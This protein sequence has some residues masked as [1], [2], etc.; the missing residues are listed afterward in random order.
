MHSFLISFKRIYFSIFLILILGG[1]FMNHLS[2]AKEA[3][4]HLLIDTSF[5]LKVKKLKLKNGLTV[6]FYP[7]TR[8]DVVTINLCI[9]VGSAFEKDKE[10]G[11]THLIEHMIFKGT[12][13]MGPEEIAKSI[14][15]LGGYINAFTSYDYTCYYVSGPSK[16][17]DTALKILSESVFNPYFP[18]KELEK[19]KQVVLEEMRMRLDRPLSVL[20]EEA[21][22]NSYTKYPYKRPIIGYEKTVESFTREDLLNYVHRFYSPQNAYLIVVGNLNEKEALQKIEKFFSSIP[23][24]EIKKVHFPEEP[25]N[26][27]PKFFWIKRDVKENYFMLTFPGVSFRSEDLPFVDLLVQILGGSK[28]SRFYRII[29]REKNLVNAIECS[30]FTPYGPGLIEITGTTSLEKFEKAL[31]A[32]LEE[33][34]KIKTLPPQEEELKRAKM[35]LLSD[36][37]Y[38]QETS[39][40]LARTIGSFELLRGNYRDVEWYIKKIEEATPEDI[41]NTAKKYLDL[42]KVV[43]TLLSSKKPFEE[44]YFSELVKNETASHVEIYTLKNKLK[45]ILLPRKDI[46]TFAIS[47]VFPG[48]TRLETKDTNGLFKALS[49]LWTRG[50]THY[51]ADEIFEKLSLLG[52]TINGFSGRNTFGLKGVFLSSYLDEGLEIFA[53][54]VKHPVFSQE[55]CNKARNTLISSILTQEDNPFSLALKDFLAYIFPSHPYGLN[56]E[57]SKKFFEHFT[58]EDM[59]K[60]YEKFA[61]PSKGVL[62]I[63]GDFPVDYVKEKIKNLFENWK[64]DVK[65]S[66]KEEKTPP[67]PK[68]K[69]KFV[70]KESFQTQIFLGFQT[71][72]LNSSE[73]EA[74]ELLSSALSGQSGRLFKIL[75]EKEALAYTV[76]PI[77]IFYPKKSVFL[78]YIGCAPKKTEKAIKGFWKIIDDLS[79]NGLTEEELKRGKNMIVGELKM[80]EQSNIYKAETMAVDEVL[81][82]GWNYPEKFV[83]KVE[84]LTNEN[85]KEVV[86]KYLTPENS[87]LFILG[88][89]E[90]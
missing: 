26:N 8:A 14:E 24:R 2:Q 41:L 86:K 33:I 15:D 78:F 25:F 48:G 69:E 57:G 4:S 12:K 88:P 34:Q 43:L 13:D 90:K 72:G 28:A 75:R 40:G 58:H 64:K 60:A 71:P 5:L 80:S 82:L 61:I 51:T 16:V 39:E 42:N 29:K 56:P 17:F 81:G 19:E 47:L 27:K 9:H 22:K 45:V 62:T 85:I 52:G 11:I 46:P 23:E 50:T 3:D 1:F 66:Y 36:F 54:I 76:V 30:D 89:E 18:E 38:S 68:E 87:F 53:E 67:K 63:V 37:I 31:K 59:I 35:E 49:Y 7:Y 21:M 65:V 32:I 10:A 77:L 74:L 70:K 6:I 83:K 44:D 79:Q 73:K 20:F 55:E 84:S